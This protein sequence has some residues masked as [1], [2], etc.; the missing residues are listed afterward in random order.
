MT[1]IFERLRRGELISRHDPEIGRFDEAADNAYRLRTEYNT[2]I[3]TREER[4]E[5]LSEIIR[6]QPQGTTTIIPPFYCDLGFNLHLGRDILINYDCVLLD[7]ADITIGDRTLIGPQT[8]LVTASHPLDPQ[9]R[10]A[11]PLATLARPIVIGE[12]VWIGAGVSVLPG[13]TVGSGAVIGAGAV[14][15]RDVPANTVMAGCPARVLRHL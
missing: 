11:D 5:L 12:N 4:H 13:V 9:V 15:T 7:C 3:M 14:V 6:A 8:R 1:D 10:A 2:R